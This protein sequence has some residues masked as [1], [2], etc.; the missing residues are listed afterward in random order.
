MK[1]KSKQTFCWASAEIVGWRG[2]FK[3]DDGFGQPA[4]NKRLLSVTPL[5]NINIS[6]Q[7]EL[8][9]MGLCFEIQQMGI[10]AYKT[11]FLKKGRKFKSIF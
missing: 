2:L 9:K 4:C 7:N 3:L 5:L 6:I 11:L 1:Q 8:A 10:I